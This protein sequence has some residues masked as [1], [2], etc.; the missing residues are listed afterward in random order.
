[1]VNDNILNSAIL[2]QMIYHFNTL[3]SGISIGKYYN[4]CC[5]IV[6]SGNWICLW[7]SDVM[8]FNTFVRW[9]EFLEKV[10]EKNPDVKLFSCVTGRIGTHKQRLDLNQNTNPSM[11]YHRH[12]SEAIFRKKNFSVRRDSSTVSGLM[13]LFSKETWTKAGG[14]IETGIA[15]VD[16]AFSRYVSDRIG[17]VGIIEGLYVMHYYRLAEGNADHLFKL[18]S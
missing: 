1:M 6:P 12:M 9:N 8:V 16:T 7:D 2:K 3:F 4:D 14:F 5:S 11:I 13:M 15:G 17:K 18:D 10:I